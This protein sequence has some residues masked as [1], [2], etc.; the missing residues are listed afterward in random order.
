VSY[1]TSLTVDLPFADAVNRVRGALKDHGSG[2][3]I[4]ID[5]TATLRAKL[6]EASHGRQRSRR[7]ECRRWPLVSCS[8]VLSV[9]GVFMT[10]RAA[11]SPT[12][13]SQ[14]PPSDASLRRRG[15][16]YRIIPEQRVP[17]VQ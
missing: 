8:A 11:A 9:H 1:G 15:T 3:L 2:E 17:S 4:E 14:S 13:Y 5:V 12:R 6:A 7:R 10:R 16:S